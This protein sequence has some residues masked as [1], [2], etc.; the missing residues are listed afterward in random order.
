M[1]TRDDQRRTR[2][3]HNTADNVMFPQWMLGQKDW[4]HENEQQRPEIID[5]IGF[6][7]RCGAKRTEQQKVVSE[8]TADPDQK[9]LCRNAPP[10][11][12]TKT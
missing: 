12:L 5:E 10:R 1:A 9:C 8:N 6:H 4:G 3:P 7:N 2:Q 11:H